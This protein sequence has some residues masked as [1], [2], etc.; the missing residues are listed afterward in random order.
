M[1]FEK[2]AM[3]ILVLLLFF[4]VFKGFSLTQ[5]AIEIKDKGRFKLLK[6]SRN[7]SLRGYDILDTRTGKCKRMYV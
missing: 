1:K 3:V 5:Q 4:I 2:I 7:D 6:D